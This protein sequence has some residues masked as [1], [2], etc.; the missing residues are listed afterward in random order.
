MAPLGQ[1]SLRGGGGD[2]NDSGNEGSTGT[3]SDNSSDLVMEDDLLGG[4]GDD[5]GSHLDADSLARLALYNGRDHYNALVTHA[6]FDHL[7]QMMFTQIV[8]G[9]IHRVEP[10]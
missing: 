2:G 7:A 1:L 9:G 8:G 6:Q 5:D 10:V 3:D 4:C